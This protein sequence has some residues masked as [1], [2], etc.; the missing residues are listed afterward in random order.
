MLKSVS[1]FSIIFSLIIGAI[2]V[3]K[4]GYFLYN[5]VDSVRLHS[6]DK[7]YNT[8]GCKPQQ[9][10]SKSNELYCSYLPTNIHTDPPLCCAV[11]FRCLISH[12][13]CNLIANPVTC[14]DV[15]VMNRTLYYG[16]QLLRYADI[17]VFSTHNPL[18]YKPTQCSDVLTVISK[19][20]LYFVLQA[21]DV[22]NYRCLVILCE[23]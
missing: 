2:A 21:L 13:V 17:V 16:A 20:S 1:S 18:F 15:T 9:F 6:T 10:I 12:A 11:L 23:Y 14:C 19:R 5:F 22:S 4:C 8:C 3:V 7:L